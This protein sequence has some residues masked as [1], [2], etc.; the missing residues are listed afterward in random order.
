MD[1]IEEWVWRVISVRGIEVFGLI[2]M[3]K[4]YFVMGDD[5]SIV[6]FSFF[7]W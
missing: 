5:V 3:L 6:N 7:V 2:V 4:F 1:V